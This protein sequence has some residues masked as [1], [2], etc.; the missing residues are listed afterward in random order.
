[1]DVGQRKLLLIY[2]NGSNNTF[3]IK[4]EDV[5][6]IAKLLLVLGLVPIILLIPNFDGGALNSISY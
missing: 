2:G 1:M 6:W 4:F 3:W 5:R